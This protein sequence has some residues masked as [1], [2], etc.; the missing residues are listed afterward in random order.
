MDAVLL[1][2]LSSEWRT[3]LA[4]ARVDRVTSPDPHRIEIAFFGGRTESA[5]SFVLV[6]QAASVFMPARPRRQDGPPSAFAMLLRRRLGGFRVL[7][8]E[9]P[10]LDRTLTLR[11]GGR[12]EF[13]DE[14]ER[15]LVFEGYGPRPNLLLVDASGR[16][17]DAFR[18]V[19]PDAEGQRGRLPGL[20][21]DPGPRAGAQRVD[22]RTLDLA[23]LREILRSTPPAA[24]LSDTLTRALRGIAPVWAREIL[25]TLGI[26]G[27]ARG[28]DLGDGWLQAGADVVTAWDRL[29][30]VLGGEVPDPGVAVDGDGRILGAFPRPPRQFGAVTYDRFPTL[31][32]ATAEASARGEAARALEARRAA[33]V[34]EVRRRRERLLSRLGKQQEEWRE[35]ERDLAERHRAELILA[36]LYRFPDGIPEVWVE[37]WDATASTGAADGAS[38]DDPAWV[39]IALDPTMSARDFAQR[40]FARYQKAKR[41]QAALVRELERGRAELAYMDVLEDASARAQDLEVLDAL[42]REA[43]A[44]GTLGHPARPKDA[45]KGAR[46]SQRREALAFSPL[47]YRTPGGLEIRVG[48][49]A[50]E[51]DRLTLHEAGADDLWFHVAEGAG[52]HVILRKDG[53][54]DPEEDDR[55]VAAQVAAYHSPQ[56]HGSH[57]EVVMCHA[58][59]VRRLPGGRPGLVL[60]DRERS[61]SVTPDAKKITAMRMEARADGPENRE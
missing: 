43:E 51:N 53:T 15:R 4:G 28:A 6:P 35:S 46:S 26:E 32:D 14:E 58:G 44:A 48:R 19:A 18:R 1:Q 57:V 23:S 39:R 27:D 10:A 21:Y 5:L 50:G 8:V 45:R 31:S 38:G 12:N 9:D 24:R 7:S 49:T 36:N 33:L 25:V 17:T 34:R 54:R 13:G 55:L 61:Y 2:G 3:R 41:R 16:I 11:L 29:R 37:D 56:A 30:A 60:Y 47:R 20:A 40:L 59:R 22:P 42:A 52:A